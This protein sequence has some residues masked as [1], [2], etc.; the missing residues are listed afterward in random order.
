MLIASTF[1][2]FCNNS[3]TATP[4]KTLGGGEREGP[5]CKVRQSLMPKSE[6]REVRK[7]HLKA[8]LPLNRVKDGGMLGISALPMLRRIVYSRE[9]KVRSPATPERGGGGAKTVFPALW[10]RGGGRLGLARRETPL[11][12]FSPLGLHGIPAE[13]RR[14]GMCR[15]PLLPWQLRP[16][17]VS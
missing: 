14:R 9:E 13:A 1:L 15:A 2:R 16:P 12:G 11:V 17:A 3:P 4:S 6:V 5:R 10:C 8:H 7:A